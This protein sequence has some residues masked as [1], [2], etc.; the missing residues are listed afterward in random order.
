MTWKSFSVIVVVITFGVLPARSQPGKFK[1]PAGVSVSSY[2]AGTVWVKVKAFYQDGFQNAHHGSRTLSKIPKTTIKPLINFGSR[3]KTAARVSPKKLHVDIGQYFKLTF[4]KAIPLEDQINDLYATGL[5]EVVEP[6]YIEQ[7]LF[8][9]NDPAMSSQYYLNLI[10]A[11]EAWDITKG[12]SSIVIGIVDTGGDLNHPDLQ[13]NIYVDPADPTDGIDNDGDGYID[14][15]RGWDFSGADIALIG[16]PGFQGDNNPAVYSGNRFGHGTMVAGCASAST[17][18]GIGISGV[19]FNTKLLFTKHYADNQADNSNSYSS[20]LYE[21]VLYAALHGAKIINCSWGNPNP[22]TIAQDLIEFVT[23][24]LGCLVV[25]AAGNS[26]AETPLYPAAYD[27]VLSVAS[28]DQNDLRSWF[29]N[30]GKTIDIT[31]PGSD[32]YTTNY[33]NG[34]RTDSGTSLSAPIVSGAAALVWAKNP[35]LT[36]LQV[37]EQLRISSDETFYLNNTA[38]N[39]KLGKGRLDIARALSLQSP[40]VRAS[41]QLLVNEAGIVPEPGQNALLTF[42]FTNF[43]KTSSPALTVSLISSSPYIT[44]TQNQ[45]NPGALGTNV[46]VSNSAS[47]FKLTIKSNLPTDQSVEALLIFSDGTYYDTQLISFVLPSFIDVNENNVTTTI[48]SAGRIGYANTEGHSNGAGFVYNDQQLLYEMGVIMGTSSSVIF[49][50]VRGTGGLYNQD[51]TSASKI[52]KHTPGER[53]FSEITGS[54]RN[55]PAEGSESLLVSYRS[56]VRKED[57][58]KDFVILEYKIKNTTSSQLT[59]FYMGLFADW[60]IQSGGASD[61]AAW[62]NGTRLGYVFPAQLASLPR[63]GIQALTGTPNYYAIDNDNTIPG[64]PFGIFDG[65]TDAEKFS[66]ISSG[67][68]K[69]T[70]GGSSGNDISHVVSVGPYT[71]NGGDEIT[72]AFAL[73]GAKSTSDLIASAKYADSL[74]NY[75]FNAPKPMVDNVEVCYG[76]QATLEA[77]GALRFKWYSDLIGGSAIFSGP[78]FTIIDL[79]KDSLVFVSNADN[80]Y[81]SLRTPVSIKVRPNPI[82]T[83]SGNLELC[84]GESVVLSSSPGDE[85]TWSTTKK[86]QSISV[87][88]A[89][90]Y[91]VVVRDGTLECESLPIEVIF[92]PKPTPE[93]SYATEAGNEIVLT[94]QSTNAASWQWDFGDGTK[95]VEENPSH[96]YSLIGNYTITLTATSEQGCE[97]TTSRSVGIITG[98]EPTLENNFLLYPNPVYDDKLFISRVIISEPV[99]INIFNGQGVV[100]HHQMLSKQEYESVL[101]TSQLASGVY[102]L[103][104]STKQETMIKTIVLMR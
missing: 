47:P 77:S 83:S 74:Y 89:G 79:K 57:P 26:N 22:S 42:D 54:Y 67:L 52:M 65:F 50:N 101:N 99:E 19:G 35:S 23:L 84:E 5:F 48:T 102:H 20:N 36:P 80:T 56:M 104:I 27:Y 98:I 43:L 28:S 78:Q 29:S 37:A 75:T 103:R 39:N 91:N 7:S 44:I 81:E 17:N 95:S 93:F 96:Q 4:D 85:Y 58:Y 30:Y 60:D 72:I 2:E 55:A 87:T 18:D 64:N 32:I 66:A 69:V 88:S 3:N 34:Y 70:A 63:A 14:N 92:N 15:N 11:A 73:H 46:T 51:F 21:G 45:F 97:A 82:I 59:N 100:V 76:G 24:D 68:G 12:S 61:K 62:D 6:V 94:N 33:D 71:I 13:N 41:K 86:T 25:A 9:P 53:S 8:I 38:Y 16:T 10:K 40:S 90:S 1:L 31:A 49:D